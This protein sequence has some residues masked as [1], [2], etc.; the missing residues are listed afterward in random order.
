MFA[1]VAVNLSL[2]KTFAIVFNQYINVAIIIM[3]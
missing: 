3:G 2:V 1:I